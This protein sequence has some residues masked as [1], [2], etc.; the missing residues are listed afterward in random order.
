[1]ARFVNAAQRADRQRRIHR[2]GQALAGH[3][4]QVQ[5]DAAIGHLE[6]VEKIAAHF[7][8]GLKLVR[9]SNAARP[10]R[11]DREHAT[12]NRARFLEFFLAQLLDNAEIHRCRDRIHVIS[13]RNVLPG[14][15]VQR[16]GQFTS[17][18]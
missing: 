12:L 7:R 5:T 14:K 10:K 9:D 13:R 3:V 15:G 1:L 6:I 11:L 18:P 16:Q 8:D 2:G 4:T 17:G